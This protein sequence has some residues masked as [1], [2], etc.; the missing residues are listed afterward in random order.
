M[1][2][3]EK[4]WMNISSETQVCGDV[5]DRRREELEVGGR[6]FGLTEESRRRL[7]IEV[8]KLERPKRR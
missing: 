6:Q 2:L 7:L 4:S 1:E 3:P 8:S 5:L